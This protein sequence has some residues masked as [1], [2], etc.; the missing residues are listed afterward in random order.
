M[1]KK[2]LLWIT[3]I[4]LLIAILGVAYFMIFIYSPP[5][6][7]ESDLVKTRLMPL[8]AKMR[9]KNGNFVASGISLQLNQNCGETVK[10][11]AGRKMEKWGVGNEG[12]ELI[13]NVETPFFCERKTIEDESY[14]LTVK[15]GKIE[16]KAPTIFGA[17][18]GLETLGQM[19][20]INDGKV[21]IPVCEIKDAPRY[22]WRGLMVD[23][24]RHWIPKEVILRII[25][26]M[27]AVKLNVLHLHLTEYQGFRIE[28][29]EFPK[30]H[31]MGS[32]GNY[33]SQDD[34]KEIISFAADRGIRVVPEFDLPGHSTSW[35]VGYPGLA[36]APG[37]YELDTL[38]GILKP[39]ID[40][41]KEEVYDFL[42]AFFDEMSSLF[43]DEYI[44]IGGD[45]VNPHD[46]KNN[47]EIQKFMKN[48]GIEDEHELQAYF[49]ARL[50]TILEK[51]GKKMVGWD[52]IL[53]PQLDSNVVVQSWRGQK[54]L[55]QA[56]KS[57][58]KAIL[59]AGWYLD[60]KLP[61]S[62]H[63]KVDPEVL[64][65]AI[66][67]EPD[68]N[69]WK[70]Y[71][72]ELNFNDNTI[73]LEMTL[74]GEGENL[75]GFLSMMGTPAGFE[76]VKK[77]GNTI[78]FKVDS[79]FGEL[80]CT[81][82]I[83]GGKLDGT[84][85]LGFLKA[86]ITGEQTGGTNIPGTSPPEV[87][88]VEPLT[89]SEKQLILG[90]EAC[91]WSEVVT[92]KNIESRI[93]P[94][95]AAIAEKLW[96]PA[97]LTQDVNN[98][99]RRLIITDRYLVENGAAHYKNQLE[100][101]NKITGNDGDNAVLN[102]VKIL[103]EVKY[104]SRMAYFDPLTVNTPLNGLADA[105]MPESFTALEFDKL[106]DEFLEDSTR[107]KNAETIRIKFNGWIENHQKILELV[108]AG[109][110]TASLK[111]LSEKLKDASKAGLKL[112]DAQ[113]NNTQI[114]ESEKEKLQQVLKY[115]AE[116]EV[117][118]EVA[119]VSSVMKLMP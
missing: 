47:P 11:A 92:A 37:P 76:K 67:I 36:S 31:E 117:G 89:E 78:S 110:K 60:H 48:N 70:T 50:K 22:P 103:E 43:P 108:E 51:H 6:I 56:V 99:Y 64:T 13:I 113:I 23:V 97:S 3:G 55:W 96:S 39:V 25:D 105:A 119:V 90:G 33:Y 79:D 111:S 100:I 34:M 15:P 7:P 88:K 38:F 69:N 66:T 21:S 16:L 87:E 59:S 74:Y 49:N 29:K 83:E 40:P 26:G 27:A 65:N 61:A 14:T 17:L 81:A 44:H 10:K 109:N 75:R 20:E 19:A 2:I 93:W 1:I 101:V 98:M 30:L 35:L 86:D 84:F 42:D 72:I 80:T 41:T 115:A 73:P 32:N 95:T 24:C 106:V 94:R 91:M 85:G 102:L 104:Y 45:E 114:S 52:E 116:P 68:T 118:A 57:N 107:Q 58:K 12:K 77:E 63:Y 112:A 71:S 62:D 54:S 5:L 53:H 8:P 46:W 9:L 28:S 4:V 18:W 82:N